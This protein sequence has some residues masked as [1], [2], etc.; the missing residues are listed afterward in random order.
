MKCKPGDLAIVR[1]IKITPEMNGR[2][3][4]VIRRATH[5]E[6]FTDVSGGCVMLHMG[7]SN[8]AIWV[9]RTRE[10]MPWRRNNGDLGW[11][12]ETPI[13]DDLLIPISGVPLEEEIL[14]EVTA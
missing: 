1:G 5:G 10:P 12:Y 11:Y 7:G 2:V 13:Y 4:E 8:A 3:V 6:I 14:D 9:V